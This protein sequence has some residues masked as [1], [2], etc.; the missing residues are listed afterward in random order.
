MPADT[1]TD[2]QT[3]I[4]TDTHS[5]RDLESDRFTDIKQKDIFTDIN[6]DRKQTDIHIDIK[7]DIY[8]DIQA[9]MQTERL[10]DAYRHTDKHS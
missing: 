4:K 3:Y 5:D 2:R 9:R 7:T 8:T 10:K 6:I 1:W